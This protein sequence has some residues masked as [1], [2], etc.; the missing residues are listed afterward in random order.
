MSDSA[1]E[2]GALNV[3]WSGDLQEKREMGVTVDIDPTKGANKAGDAKGIQFRPAVLIGLGGTGIECLRRAKQKILNRVGNLPTV[4]FVYVDADQKS[5]LNQPGLAP[6][7]QSEQCFIGGYHL[8][9]VLDHPEAHRWLLEQIPGKLAAGHYEKAAKGDGCGQIRAV[10]RIALLASMLNFRAVVRDAI[11]KVEKLAAQQKARLRMRTTNETASVAAEP[12]IYIVSSIA[13]GTGSGTFIDAALLARALTGHRARMVGI[14]VLPEAFDKEVKGDESQ[15]RLMRANAYASLMELQYLQDLRE[16]VRLEA[17]INAAG[18]KLELPAGRKLFDLTYLI[19]FKNESSKRFSRVEDVYELV[20]RLLLHENATQFSVNAHSVE[21]NLNTLR[22][23]ERCP[24]TLLPRNFSSFANTRLGFPI[25]RMTRFC[26]WS[27][28]R[29]LWEAE[30]L[31]SPLLPAKRSEE[32]QSF[33]STNE[34]DEQGP[35]DQV[36]SRLLRNPQHDSPISEATEGVSRNFGHDKKPK[37][38]V[39]L[40]RQRMELFNARS[41]PAAETAIKQNLQFYLSQGAG[42][43]RPLEA[44]LNAF[45]NSCL[46]RFGGRGTASILEELIARA[47]AL[48]TEMLSENDLW[49]NTDRKSQT[50]ALDRALLDL[51]AVSSVRAAL[52]S[53]DERLKTDA[54]TAFQAIVREELRTRARTAAVKVY[55]ELI[56]LTTN[57]KR[58]IDVFV[59]AGESFA[60]EL[61][62]SL[63]SLRVEGKRETANFVVEMDITERGDLE[64]YYEENRVPPSRLLKASRDAAGDRQHYYLSLL[65]MGRESLLKEF[66]ERASGLYFP[67]IKGLN[68]VQYISSRIGDGGALAVKLSELFDMCVPFWSTRLPQV[69][70]QYDQYLALGCM[71]N[72]SGEADGADFPPEIQQWV[73]QYKRATRGTVAA[74][75]SI[76]PTGAPY[77]IELVRYTHGARAWYLNDAEEWKRKY[78]QV[79][80]LQAFPMHVFKCLAPIPDLLPD[81]NK[82]ARQVF[83]LGMALGFIAKRGDY[84]YMNVLPSKKEAG[85]YTVPMGTEWR[86]VFGEA[87]SRDL[88][89]DTGRVVFEFKQKKQP[90]EELLLSQGR[91]AACESL[92]RDQNRIGVILAA[93]AEYKTA[94]GSTVVRPQL[95]AYAEYLVEHADSAGKLRKQIEHEQ[96]LIL[97]YL[98]NLE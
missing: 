32:A 41:L 4:A 12:V 8:Q 15:L 46:D 67:K 66:G 31:K 98:Q 14:F 96:E 39:A 25:E 3:D 90:K 58:T 61:T 71:P 29:E 63:Q 5:Y 59:A 45:V 34:L 97:E 2:F 55:D 88:P 73:Q 62:D 44:R 68:A 48:K 80:K 91:V 82:L 21:R 16:D 54:I 42:S 28:L 78:E 92:S 50:D 30:L 94:V 65:T 76:I 56:S 22:D 52:S 23:V 20:S 86:T 74:E 38:F 72:A 7:E 79:H 26:V 47:T 85:C 64:K 53:K 40:L 37:Q 11:D 83:A 84:Y 93:L 24:E 51:G 6:V 49:I 19:D 9:P 95:S 17:L 89:A 43:D 33:L 36:L 10:G 35:V 18:E 77:E 27:T 60:R 1:Q 87:G 13:G 75:A 81:R 69:N 57:L 70:M